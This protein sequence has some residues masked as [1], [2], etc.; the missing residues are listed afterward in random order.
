MEDSKSSSSLS[1]SRSSD[2]ALEKVHTSV[3]PAILETEIV[4]TDVKERRESLPNLMSQSM[5][6]ETKHSSL[7]HNVRL[8][9]GSASE[10]KRQAS[11][12]ETS[13]DSN[14]L[15]SS[16]DLKSMDSVLAE[17]MSDVRSL[18]MQQSSDKRMSLPL[19]KNKTVAKH[20]PDLVLDLPEDSN[21]PSPSEGSGPDSPV[22]AAETFAK[23]N[24]GTLKKAASMPRNI[25]STNIYGGGEHSTNIEPL[26]VTAPL[27][28]TFQQMKQKATTLPV[29][30]SRKFSIEEQH[31]TTLG[32]SFQAFTPPI[33]EKPKPQIKPK[34]PIMKKPVSRSPELSKR[35]EQTTVDSE[36]AESASPNLK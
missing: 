17:I 15:S 10:L 20:T 35:S 16:D 24:Q 5:I 18:E 4:E 11:T 21:S 9:V 34:P 19:V 36:R 6:T 25:P 3:K 31:T 2:S 33:S 14:K 12:P 13:L 1:L 26:M 7:E 27:L 23:S 28:S 30:T 22:S 32:Q 8:S 29:T